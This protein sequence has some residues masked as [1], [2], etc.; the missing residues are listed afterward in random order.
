MVITLSALIAS[1]YISYPELDNLMFAL[2]SS[3]LF[4]ILVEIGFLLND[5]KRFS[6]LQ[7]NWI[8]AKIKFRNE[9]Q[10]GDGYLDITK[11]YI[12]GKIDPNITLSYHGDGEYNG[13]AEYEEGTKWFTLTIDKNNV[14][15]G[16]GT[17]QYEK[18]KSQ[19]DVP[20]LGYFEFIIDRNKKGIY[21]SHENRLP[22]G[23]AKGIEVWKK[24]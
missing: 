1:F 7:G 20:D 22:S 14:L 21:I 6:Y 12:D 13:K 17:Y 19:Q 16:K 18:Q 5:R 3:G 10:S 15:S 9:S 4:A 23:T 8:R 2:V 11:R 24:L